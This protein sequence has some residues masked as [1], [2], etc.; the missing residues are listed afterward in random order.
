MKAIYKNSGL[1]EKEAKSRFYFP[2]NVMMENAAMA[3]E[4]A[5]LAE[6]S[7]KVLIL[8]GTGNN[9]GDGYALAR[10]LSGKV[11]SVAIFSFGEPKTDEAKLQKKMSLACGVQILSD[12]SK[13]EADSIV[14]CVFGTGFHGELPEDVA[15][16]I[17]WSNEQKVF[18]LACD[19]PSGMKFCADKT[20][21]MGALKTVL[22]ED[23][24]KDFCGKIEVAELGISTAM[25]DSCGI[26]DAYLL[27]ESDIKMPV[28]E[29]QNCHKG[30]FG[31]AVV[32]LGEKPG[33][34]IIVGTAAL[35]IG[36]GLVSV[37]D[38]G[39]SQQQF[40]MSPELMIGKEFP[41]KT[42]AV[43]L[44][45]GLGRSRHC[46]D[47][48]RGNL[49]TVIEK[50]LTF[51]ESMKTPA[52]VL[53]ADFFYLENLCQVLEKLNDVKNG[54]FVLTPHPKEM[55][56]ICKACGIENRKQFA[57]KFPNLVLVAKGANTHI[58]ANGKVF[59]CAEGTNALAKAGSG[60]V[61]AGLIMGLLAQ[62]FSAEEAAKSAVW[63]HGKAG[64]KFENNWEC[65]PFGLLEKLPVGGTR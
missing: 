60:D 32:V 24:A 57:E 29:K 49:Q 43:L 56:V 21:T 59:V 17:E 45:S 55:E 54:R 46:E 19:I 39:L 2:E 65:T 33:A 13:Y 40:M 50:T 58:F 35:K 20:I 4:Q 6:H 28:R 14:D 12:Y 63:I 8:C 7:K 38:N 64:A 41:E 25:F 3:L 15:R 5:V 37:V 47:A 62:G 22:F 53:D 9:G 1:V 23:E 10:R 51:L 48:V 31:H 27:E 42:S 30:S 44:G 16:A 52:A 26:P 11:E 36:A 61:L 18:R 34:G